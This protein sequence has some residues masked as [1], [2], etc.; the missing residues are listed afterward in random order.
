MSASDAQRAPINYPP[1]FLV[2]VTPDLVDNSLCDH[3]AEPPI[4]F[5]VH[6]WRIEFGNVSRA[7]KPKATYI[8]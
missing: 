3:E 7:Q 1:G 5:C 4:C 6:D 8:Q 2:A